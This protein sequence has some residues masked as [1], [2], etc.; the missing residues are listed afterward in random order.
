[1]DQSLIDKI[2]AITGQEEE[3]VAEFL[4]NSS[5]DEMYQLIDANRKGDD[6]SI[7]PLVASLIIKADPEKEPEKEPQPEVKEAMKKP[8]TKLTVELPKLRDPMA[9]ELAKGQYQPKATPNKKEQLARMD[10][11]HRS[12]RVD[13]SFSSTS[14]P[15]VEGVLGMS[16]MPYIKK[17]LT[18][19]GRPAE[20]H[21]IKK[22]MEDFMGSFGDYRGLAALDSQRS[23]GAM[24][25]GPLDGV[26][27][28]FPDLEQDQDAF[29]AELDAMDVVQDVADVEEFDTMAYADAFTDNTP[30]P[31][32]ELTNIEAVRNAFATINNNVRDIKV[33]EFTEV[34]QLLSDLMSSLD[35]IGNNITGK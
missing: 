10:R 8:D 17:M 19:A 3:A 28:D 23:A 5:M 15:V 12:N 34:R 24:A 33:S 29:D 26:L 11:K 16:S 14:E 35:R 27:A 2:M 32:T 21:D 7:E 9:R 6:A 20:E 18:L 1:M 22:A 31:E 25:A 4:G 13:D 30:P